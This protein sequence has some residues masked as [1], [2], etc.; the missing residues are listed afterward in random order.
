MSLPPRPHP[1]ARSPRVE[2]VNGW[3]EMAW[4]RGLS[5]KPSLEPEAL[6]HKALRGAPARG[7][8]AGRSAEDVDDFRIRLERLCQSLMTEARLNPL[9]LTIAHGQLARVIRQR[10]HL[11]AMW[12]EKPEILTIPLAPPV[13]VVGQMRSGTT[14]VH[15]L[16]ASDP[17]LAA[18]RFC[19]SWHPLPRTPDTRPAWSALSLLLA[20]ALDPWLDSIHPFG[21]TRADEELGWLAG[22][23]D[24]C[25]Y[26]A[27]W[28][29]PSFSAFS[30]ARDPVPVYREFARLLRTDADWHHNAARPRVLKVPQFSEDLPA[31]L[32]QFPEA[33]VVLTRRCE[34]DLARS[35]ASLV[36]NQMTIQ[37]DECD[38]DWIETEVRRKIALR[39]SR[40]H[41]A[42][43][44]FTGPL[45][46]VDFD[47]L[48]ADWN[49]EI[50]RV[51][52]ELGLEFCHRVR[53][54]MAA[55]QGRA[56]QSPHHSHNSQLRQFSGE[57]A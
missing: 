2:R 48:S 10:L 1:C 29:I 25:A 56:R 19:D 37:S 9:G 54:S 32:A 12:Q 14:R 13:I 38:Y 5:N 6:W 21:V 34:D 18:T 22:A 16:L 17:G 44:R 43:S 40:M 36:A 42:L 24:H 28:R 33:R 41:H 45:A 27:Q 57:A 8:E 50:A 15:R 11:G 47:A 7:E 39:E 23:L 35:A 31:L 53:D 46:V 49:T 26:E 51:Y 20:R 30:E 52:E 55:E 4:R 3:L